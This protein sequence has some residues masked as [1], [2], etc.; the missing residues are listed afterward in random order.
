[1][2]LHFSKLYSHVLQLWLPQCTSGLTQSLPE[3]I[4]KLKICSLTCSYNACDEIFLKISM[5]GSVHELIEM[6]Q[7]TFINLALLAAGHTFLPSTTSWLLYK[8]T[9]IFSQL[10]MHVFKKKFSLWYANAYLIHNKIGLKIHI[11]IM[12]QSVMQI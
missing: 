11:K 1:M 6:A 4:T 8:H 3:F 5:G 10:L 9:I 12:L 7:E 2:S